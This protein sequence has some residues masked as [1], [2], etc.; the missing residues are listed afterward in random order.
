MITE[1]DPYFLEK[2]CFEGGLI[3]H[4][5]LFICARGGAVKTEKVKVKKPW[6]FK[7]GKEPMIRVLGRTPEEVVN[8]VLQLQEA[9]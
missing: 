7:V 2:T 3:K 5:R 8:K 6:V 9:K 1:G 4:G